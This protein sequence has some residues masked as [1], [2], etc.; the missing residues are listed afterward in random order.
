MHYNN[1][2]G[3]LTQLCLN[4]LFSQLGF[5]SD[6]LATEI[7]PSFSWHAVQFIME[8]RVWSMRV[9]PQGK[10]LHPLKRLS[11]D[12]EKHYAS[13]RCVLQHR[14]KKVYPKCARQ[15]VFIVTAACVLET[16]LFLICAFYQHLSSWHA[17][18]C[19]SLTVSIKTG[20][21]ST[22]VQGL[23]SPA[24]H[25]LDETQLPFSWYN[26][27]FSSLCSDT[28]A[29]ATTHDHFLFGIIYQWFGFIALP[30]GSN[31]CWSVRTRSNPAVLMPSPPSYLVINGRLL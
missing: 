7:V 23:N 19:L 31:I 3:A 13:C 26:T 5:R 1:G 25:T 20:S 2:S 27:P 17:E 21:N 28:V 12:R 22:N 24:L 15:L 16:S 9:R 4:C 18:H 14:W 10:P 8:F 29:K 30:I 11:F 6:N